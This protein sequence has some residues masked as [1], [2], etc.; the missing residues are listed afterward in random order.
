M[1]T[2]MMRQTTKADK[3]RRASKVAW[4]I[5]ASM[6]GFWVYSILALSISN[7]TVVVALT[8]LVSAGTQYV[9]SLIESA[10]FDGSLPAPWSADWAWE[11]SLPWLWGG[12]IVCLLVDVMMNLG[13]VSL[14]TSKLT[15][16]NIGQEQF[17]MT[18]EFVSF[19]A[20][21]ATF[22]L[23]VLFAVSSELLEEFAVYT[24]TGG[25]KAMG[26]RAERIKKALQ[27]QN[28]LGVMVKQFDE[29][30]LKQATDAVKGKAQQFAARQQPKEP[31]VDDL[32]VAR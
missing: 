18:N 27:Q 8:V 16:T 21:S 19:V 4:L 1:K 17:Q 7:T 25:S 29:A 22:V 11:G 15:D 10:L 30:R 31:A 14:F 24:E 28:E 26:L 2:P 32:E 23:A 5:S 13:G 3:L 9:I 12:A 20:K 6:T